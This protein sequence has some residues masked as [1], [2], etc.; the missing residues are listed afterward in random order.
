M[1]IFYFPVYFQHVWLTIKAKNFFFSLSANPAIKDGLLLDDPKYRTL[2]ML[3]E[4][5]RPKTIL[6]TKNHAID[7]VKQLMQKETIDFPV[8]LKPNIGYRG[9]L[10]NKIENKQQLQDF[11]NTVTVDY[12]LQEYIDFPLEIGVFYYRLPNCETGEIPSITLK[13]F[14]KVKGDGKST[15]ATLISKKPRAILQAKRLAEK[16][17]AQWNTVIPEGEEILLEGIGSHNRGT[18]FIN[19][20]DLKDNNLQQVFDKLNKQMKGFYFGRFDIRTTSIK[21]LKAGKNFKILEVNGVGAEPTHIYDPGYKL[22]KAW[23]ELLF[24]WRIIYTI[25][26]QNKKNGIALPKFSEGKRRWKAFFRVKR[27]LSV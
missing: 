18:K 8:I 1:Q 24:L 3:P 27:N 4:A 21:D 14:L 7:E 25:A 6:I 12:L 17:K 11:L 23:K 16:F 5:H 26:M 22:F 10:V 15:L 19:A 9:L 2:Q 13:E 20:N